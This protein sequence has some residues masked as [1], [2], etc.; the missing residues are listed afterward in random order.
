[1]TGRTLIRSRILATLLPIITLAAATPSLGANE[2]TTLPLDAWCGTIIEFPCYW[3]I[4]DAAG[5]PTV[6]IPL[7]G[8]VMVILYLRN[9]DDVSAVQT[10]FDFGTWT[11]IFGTW[12]CRSNQVNGVVP[13]NPGGPLAG[14]IA[15]A[16]DCVLGGATTPIGY[17]HFMPVTTPG[18]LTQIESGYP[19]G[20]CVLDCQVEKTPVLPENRGRICAGMPGG[21]DACEPAATPVEW[22]TWGSIKQQYH[23]SPQLLRVPLTPP[24]YSTPT[25]ARHVPRS[26]LRPPRCESVPRP[27]HAPSA[28]AVPHPSPGRT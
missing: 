17:M 3:D 7:E 6:N 19:H 13:V 20:T 2:N 24:G 14:T 27:A 26:S 23:N 28:A 12:E 10:A 9:F 15:T 21:V 18:C 8:R 22:K 1:M 5:P 11:F 4:C 16:F 25:S